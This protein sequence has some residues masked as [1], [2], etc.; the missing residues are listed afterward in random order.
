MTYLEVHRVGASF[1]VENLK[2]LVLVFCLDVALEFHTVIIWAFG[3]GLKYTT[4]IFISE[5]IH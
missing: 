1:L 3:K 2:I 4:L 5:F